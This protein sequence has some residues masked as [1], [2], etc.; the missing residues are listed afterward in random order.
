MPGLVDSGTPCRKATTLEALVNS[1]I[2][3]GLLPCKILIFQNHE[4]ACRGM[5]ESQINVLVELAIKL[6]D[7]EHQI[8]LS[9][10]PVMGYV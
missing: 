10:T 3:T 2:I 4:F 5:E 8:F 7:R 6:Q 1:F 9:T